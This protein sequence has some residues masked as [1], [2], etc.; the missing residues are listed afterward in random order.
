M[1]FRGDIHDIPLGAGQRTPDLWFN[2]SGFERT[3]AK[4]LANNIRTF[5][6][7]L[8]GVRADGINMLDLAIHKDFHIS[9]RFRIQARAEAEG[10][11]NHP[12]FGG[13][14]ANPSSTLFGSV[15]STQTNGEEARRIF[16]GVKLMF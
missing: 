16:V 6:S 2:T 1:L 14:N 15:T 4:Q 5:P 9:E 12:L 7:R 8:S 3:A 11:L 10:A 13:P